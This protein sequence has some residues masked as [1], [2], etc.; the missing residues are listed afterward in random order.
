VVLGNRE[1]NYVALALSKHSTA[2]NPPNTQ[3]CALLSEQGANSDARKA[4]A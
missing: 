1:Q 3:N 4:L 2:V